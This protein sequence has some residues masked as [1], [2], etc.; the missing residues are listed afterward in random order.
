MWKLEKPSLD[1][2]L[3]DI[4]NI[5]AESNRNLDEQSKVKLQYVF[6]LYERNNGSVAAVDLNRFSDKEKNTLHDMYGTKTYENQP[7]FYIRKQL[8]DQ[9]DLCPVCGINPPSQLDHQMPRSQYKPLSLCR[10]NLVPLCG[11]CNN[12][13]RAK[14]YDEFIHPYYAEFPSGV[15]FLIAN[16]HVNTKNHKM[17][18]FY[19]LDSTV[20]HDHVLIQ[21]IRSQVSNVKL[22]RRLL[23]ESHRFIGDLLFDNKF[24]N[25]KALKTFLQ[26]EMNRYIHRYGLNDWR[27]A[28]LR[29]LYFCP[30]FGIEE[31]EWLIGRIPPINNGVNV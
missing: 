21:K 17:S 24:A 14:P 31:A 18:W 3:K 1:D 8:F 13:K 16:V 9:K 5:I 4:E 7:L 25:N 28:I 6:R 27:S 29:A 26:R 20:L 22:F 10:L 23:R 15:I 19:S 11:V 2:A 12:K 30:S